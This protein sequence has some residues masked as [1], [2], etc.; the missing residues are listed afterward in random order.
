[1]ADPK[2]LLEQLRLFVDDPDAFQGDETQKQELLKLSR[3][4]AST[5]ESPFETLQR[6]IYSVRNTTISSIP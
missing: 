2:I 1:M 4:A 6:L 5:L 3:Q